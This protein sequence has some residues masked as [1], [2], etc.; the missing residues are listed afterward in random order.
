MNSNYEKLVH[1]IYR[2]LKVTPAEVIALRKQVE[3]MSADVL[4]SDGSHGVTAALCHSFEVTLQLMQESIL[5]SKRSGS[6]ST[7]VADL[8][9]GHI[10]LLEATVD[11]FA[12]R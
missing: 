1:E 9:R 6:T 4:S 3:K 12:R 5:A 7:A 10:K 8:M 11:A 2:D